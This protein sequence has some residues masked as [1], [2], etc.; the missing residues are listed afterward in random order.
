MDPSTL[1]DGTYDYRLVR[2]S[3]ELENGLADIAVYD[4]I[5][6][7]RGTQYT[8]DL[9]FIR[10]LTQVPAMIVLHDSFEMAAETGDDVGGPSGGDN[11]AQGGGQLESGQQSES[12]QPGEASGSQTGSGSAGLAMLAGILA[13]LFL[14][15]S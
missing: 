3:R 15:K 12:G 10:G 13:L 7:T 6:P 8:P 1:N 2:P 11:L 5:P 4:R 14:L 9:A